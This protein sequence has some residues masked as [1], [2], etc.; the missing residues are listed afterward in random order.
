[1]GAAGAFLGD[2]KTVIPIDRSVRTGIHAILA[3][4]TLHRVDYYQSVISPV[5]SLHRAGWQAGCITAMIAQVS[6]ISYFNLGDRPSDMLAQFQPELSGFRL[7]FGIRSPIV[8]NMLVFAGDLAII[9]SV[10]SCY[11]KSKDFQLVSSFVNNPGVE[12]QTGSR[13]VFSF[14]GIRIQ[15]FPLFHLSS[16]DPFDL[17][18]IS[19]GGLT[20]NIL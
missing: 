12:A 18:Q 13:I 9:A 1:M 3:A 11:I 7:G 6:N 16:R 20:G 19:A 17:Y 5:D 8:N 14:P 2:I 10:T 4:G 15:F